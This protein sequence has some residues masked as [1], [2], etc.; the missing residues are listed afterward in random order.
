MLIQVHDELVFE[1]PVEFA[2]DP[3][4]NERIHH[5]MCSGIT[6]LLGKNL[7]VP[8][9]TSGKQGDNWAACK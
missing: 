1:I 4:V 9:D 7:L 5:H 6:K 2:N 8:L 3:R